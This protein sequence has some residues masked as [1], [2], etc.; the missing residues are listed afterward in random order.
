MEETEA[1]RRGDAGECGDGL[2]G[3]RKA[4]CD[5]HLIQI[6]GAGIDKGG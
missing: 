2:S 4:F 3:L 5:S 6:H 1:G